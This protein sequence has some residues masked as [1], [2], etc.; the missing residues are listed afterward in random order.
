MRR[1]GGIFRNMGKKGTSGRTEARDGQR[2]A[3]VH[4]LGLR[5]MLYGDLNLAWRTMLELAEG[6]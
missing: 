3:Q 2:L 1:P 6:E 4:S 5:Q